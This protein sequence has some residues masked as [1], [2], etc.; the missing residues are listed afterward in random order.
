MITS[1]N[2]IGIT[3]SPK[4]WDR[5]IDSY[6]IINQDMF[7][8]SIVPV[9]DLSIFHNGTYAGTVVTLLGPVYCWLSARQQ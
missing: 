5:I 1:A 4:V 2:F 6:A 3:Q 9:D 7:L 8:V